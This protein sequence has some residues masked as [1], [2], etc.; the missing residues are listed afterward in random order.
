MS[1]G[2]IATEYAD[3]KIANIIFAAQAAIL[4]LN[5]RSVLKMFYQYIKR[6]RF[7]HH[8]ERFKC[9]TT[10]DWIMMAG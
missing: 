3:K 7:A 5:F 9:V 6:M 8:R 10:N 2:F 4:N 1:D